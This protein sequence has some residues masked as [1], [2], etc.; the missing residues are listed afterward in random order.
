MPFA[1]DVN[2]IG[3]RCHDLLHTV[4]FKI[5]SIDMRVYVCL[6]TGFEDME[7][8][9]TLDVLRRAGVDARTVSMTGDVMV[10]TAHGVTVK[11]DELF[12]EADFD[13]AEMVVLPG[14]LPGA[15]N[16]DAHEGLAAVLRGFSAKGKWVAA[17]CA[18]PMVL[19]HLGLL[20]G[21]RATCYPGFESHL[22]G[23][24]T[25]GSPVEVDGRVVTGK[26]PGF[27]FDF[28]L[29]LVAQ[30]CGRAKADEVASGMLLK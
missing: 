29:T 20:D 24:A 12:E 21:R 22:H 28:A 11:C 13:A 27:T 9:G 17:I 4:L 26:G 1:Y 19:G 5:T 14:G 25:A 2:A 6:A 7:A 30:L 15:T 8:L 18:A 3:I 16:L 10:T 23:A